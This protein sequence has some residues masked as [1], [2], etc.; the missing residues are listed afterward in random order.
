M[1]VLYIINHNL[2]FW[3]A[4]SVHLL[5][6]NLPFLSFLSSLLFIDKVRYEVEQKDFT[7]KC[8]SERRIKE[9]ESKRPKKALS[10]YMIFVRETRAK[11][12]KKYPQMHALEVMKTVGR[13]WQDLDPLLRGNFEEQAKV[14]KQR[15]LDEMKVFQQQLEALNCDEAEED[16]GKDSPKEKSE[17][18]VANSEP[19][20]KVEPKKPAHSENS[21]ITL[22]AQEVVNGES[23]RFLSL[24]RNSPV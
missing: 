5:L 1:N 22:S 11:V 24:V 16:S 2:N 3:N 8:G 19:V 6:R 18:V 17:V 20:Q 23:N 12:C 10:A 9:W 7:K 15:F 14:D 4:L 21:C 13:L